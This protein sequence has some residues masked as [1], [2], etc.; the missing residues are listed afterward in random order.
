MYNRFD[1]RVTLAPPRRGGD[2][3]PGADRP[4][5]RRRPPS[6]RTPVGRNPEALRRLDA[7]LDGRPLEDATVAA[8]LAELHDQEPGAGR[9]PRRRWPRRLPRPGERTARVL[10][11]YRW[12]AGN[13]GRGQAR[14]FGAA[15]L[16]VL[17]TCR[18]PRLGDRGRLGRRRRRGRRQRRPRHRPPEQDGPGGREGGHPVREGAASPAWSV[19]L[20]VAVNPALGSVGLAS[21]LTSRGAS[22]TDVMLVRVPGSGHRT[23]RQGPPPGRTPRAKNATRRGP[24]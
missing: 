11:G 6:A 10:A 20:Q 22:T 19:P 8:Y 23:H 15:D 12:T 24:S 7:W 1:V 16:A 21:E 4:P 2:R 18:Q 3:A 13:R 17:A 9:A 14:P 5:P